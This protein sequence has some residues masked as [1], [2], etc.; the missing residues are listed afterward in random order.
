MFDLL[1]F[2]FRIFSTS[3]VKGKLSSLVFLFCC[4][5]VDLDV[6]DVAVRI[7]VDPYNVLV[8]VLPLLSFRQSRSCL[9]QSQSPLLLS[10]V[11]QVG[12]EQ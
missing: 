2:F 12:W 4:L 5:F 10:T 3:V 1:A 8:Y 6:S 7:T 11:L 9:Y